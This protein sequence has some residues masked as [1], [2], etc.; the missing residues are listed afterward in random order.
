M[1]KELI[2]DSS[3]LKKKIGELERVPVKS[4]QLVSAIEKARA[5]GFQYLVC[6]LQAPEPRDIRTLEA[7]DFYLTD[8]GVTLKITADNFGYSRAEC[9]EAFRYIETASILDVQK[10]KDMS[11]SLFTH[12]RFYSD[13]FY[14]RNEA[15]ALYQAWIENS[16]KGVV[17]DAVFFIPGAGFITCKKNSTAQTGEIALLGIKK[18]SRSKGH[19]TALLDKA[20]RWFRTHDVSEVDVRT[21]LRN[22]E[23]VNFY[24]KSGFFLKGYD[25][26]YGKII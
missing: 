11:I 21:Q 12:S 22:M 19:G 26:V 18:K 14:S 13:P 4:A 8:I 7:A 2:W 10:L 23:A 1:I 25:Q 17:A 16:V 24:I 5:D 6:K 15:D 3:L 9:T 20:M